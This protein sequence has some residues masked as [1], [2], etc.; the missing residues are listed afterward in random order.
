MFDSRSLIQNPA[1]DMPIPPVIKLGPEFSDLESFGERIPHQIDILFLD[2]LTVSGN[3]HFGRDVK[4]RGTVI[5]V[6][7]EGGRIDIPSGAEIENKVMTG[8]LRI[9]EH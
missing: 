3:V 4:L 9:L 5:I 1:R 8:F 2:H 7:N 6:A